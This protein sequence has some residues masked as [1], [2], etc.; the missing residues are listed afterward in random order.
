ML[1]VLGLTQFEMSYSEVK[2]LFINVPFLPPP[3][4]PSLYLPPLM[5]KSLNQIMLPGKTLEYFVYIN[6]PLI[7]LN[8]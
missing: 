4:F 2:K 6:S 8:L 5:S 7:S 1:V 3:D